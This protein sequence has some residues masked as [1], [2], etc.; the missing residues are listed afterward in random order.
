VIGLAIAAHCEIGP[1]LLESLYER[2]LC[3]ELG[4]A[5]IG[6]QRQAAVSVFY[7]GGRLD[8]GFRANIIVENAIMLEIKAA[9]AIL[10]A[11][12]A[13]ATDLSPHESDP[14]WPDYEFGCASP[15]R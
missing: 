9:S 4:N 6:C 13:Q 10:P 8:E 3:H 5:G 1:G 2:C 11:H 12:E 7:K 15:E 14:N